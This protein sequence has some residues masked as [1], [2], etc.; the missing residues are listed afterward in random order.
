[1][2]VDRA[3]VSRRIKSYREIRPLYEDVSQL[4]LS[5]FHYFEVLPLQADGY[6]AGW[7]GAVAVEEA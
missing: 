1:M 4:T 3:V 5:E 2:G 7:L 6:F